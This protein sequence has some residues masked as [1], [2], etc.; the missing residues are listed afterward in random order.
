MG[1]IAINCICF[2]FDP[3]NAQNFQKNGENI[4]VR[5][6]EMDQHLSSEMS[7]IS[8]RT[9]LVLHD[10]YQY[11]ESRYKLRS[12]GSITLQLEHFLGVSRLT[13]VQKMIKTSKVRCIFIEPQYS[14]K[15][16][17]TLIKT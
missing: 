14:Q 11:F 17:K 12:E 15:L 13:K 6:N 16:V 9:Y 7:K 8:D 1:S 3:E 2:K 10:A 4:I 5:L